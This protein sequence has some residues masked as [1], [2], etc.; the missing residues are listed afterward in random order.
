MELIN[1]WAV[2]LA[3]ALAFAL[4]E[5]WY[6]PLF[7]QAWLGVRGKAEEQLEPST[8]PF[9]IRFFAVLITAVVL[10]WLAVELAVQGWLDGAILGLVMG[11]GFITTSNASDGAF[12]RTS[13]NLFLIQSGYRVVYAVLMGALLGGWQYQQN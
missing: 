10:A 2:L 13:L 6:G 8:Q 11:I 3:A 12:L 9:I 4:G 7:G 5:I 1:W